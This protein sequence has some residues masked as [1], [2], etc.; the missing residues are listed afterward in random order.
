MLNQ[1]DEGENWKHKNFFSIQ[2]LAKLIQLVCYCPDSPDHPL[3]I[4]LKHKI[5]VFIKFLVTF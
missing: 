2:R 5:H 4:N 3:A 1:N